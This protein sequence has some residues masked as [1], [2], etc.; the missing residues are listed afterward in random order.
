VKNFRWNAKKSGVV[1]SGGVVGKERARSSHSIRRGFG[2]D[3]EAAMPR[4]PHQTEEDVSQTYSQDGDLLVED[5][6]PDES[7]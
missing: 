3:T 5:N 7:E 4:I 2:R 6:K 1:R